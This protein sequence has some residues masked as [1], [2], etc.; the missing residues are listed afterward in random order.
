MDEKTRRID[1]ESDRTDYID[2][3]RRCRGADWMCWMRVLHEVPT[4]LQNDKVFFQELIKSKSEIL[5]TVLRFLEPPPAIRGVP[6]RNTWSPPIWVQEMA[7]AHSENR[8]LMIETLKT[9]S[10]EKRAEEIAERLWV[11]KLLPKKYHRGDVYS[12]KQHSEDQAQYRLLLARSFND[13]NSSLHELPIEVIE[14]IA[15]HIKL[16]LWIIPYD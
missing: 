6:K 8:N 14:L 5:F 2:R 15:N 10:K 9:V 4:D 13:S 1:L 16:P 12:G 7:R 11:E 3:I